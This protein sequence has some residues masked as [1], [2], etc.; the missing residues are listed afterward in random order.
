MEI[1][2]LIKTGRQ[3]AD[4]QTIR[5][6]DWDTGRQVGRQAGRQAGRLVGKLS[7]QKGRQVGR[8]A[9]RQVGREVGR[10]KSWIS[11]L[12]PSSGMRTVGR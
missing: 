2:A 11:T 6:A 10:K 1:P 9:G 8:H 7:R 3:A 4:R 5:Q 12:T